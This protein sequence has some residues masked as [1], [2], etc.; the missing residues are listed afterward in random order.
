MPERKLR[1]GSST[2][3]QRDQLAPQ[4][5]SPIL[6]NTVRP[7]LP[8]SHASVSIIDVDSTGNQPAPLNPILSNVVGPRLPGNQVPSVSI[9]DVDFTDSTNAGD[10]AFAP[11]AM[12][13]VAA[14]DSPSTQL[15]G[16]HDGKIHCLPYSTI[17]TNK[18][19][20]QWLPTKLQIPNRAPFSHL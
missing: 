19:S 5:S 4:A 13:P 1:V 17:S 11:S 16:Q 9:T 12:D 10:S 3:D 2:G 15:V 14:V 6:S 7:R 18:C 8:G 20:C